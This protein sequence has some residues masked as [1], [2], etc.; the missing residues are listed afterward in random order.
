MARDFNALAMVAPV[1]EGFRGRM[2]SALDQAQAR[3]PPSPLEARVL[4]VRR[5]FEAMPPA[6]RNFVP[7]VN[8]LS[9]EVAARA[10]DRPV[11]PTSPVP[12]PVETRPG[13]AAAEPPPLG[14]PAPAA[15]P[16]TTAAQAKQ[17]ASG[18]YKAAEDRGGVLTPDLANKFIDGVEA[19]LPQTEAGKA[20]GGESPV[21]ALVKRLQ[22][23]RDK[24]MTF[25]AVQEI[26]EALGGLIDKEYGVKG[27]SKDGLKLQ[28]V[29]HSL[30]DLIDN[31]G[32]GDITGGSAG[33]DALSTAR[34][35]WSQAMKMDD[36]ERIQTRA[37]MAT[38]P[39]TSIKTQLTTLRNNPKRIRGYDAEEIA[40]LE[41]A[42]ERGKLGSALHVF[43]NRLVPLV[44]GAAEIGTHGITAGLAAAGTAHLVGGKLRSWATTLQEKRLRNAMDVLGQKVP[45]NPLDLPEAP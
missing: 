18:I 29:Q 36:L 15:A 9:P 41:T 42:A 39:A 25:Q 14:S 24:P 27:I 4:D 30:R 40:A 20:V 16:I 31:A 7:G 11:A 45:P 38:N 37:A 28:D 6:E 10:A 22:T 12:A 33:F 2:P 35:A 32:P 43:G 8:Q 5:Q 34:K 19:K 44:A 23:L 17:H 13:V 26:D 21:S 3:V 1:A